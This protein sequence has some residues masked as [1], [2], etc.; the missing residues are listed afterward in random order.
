VRIGAYQR[1]LSELGERVERYQ[2][3][4]GLDGGLMLARRI[5]CCRQPL[6]DIADHGERPVALGR[7]PLLKWLGI[8]VEIGEKFATVQLGRRL[9]VRALLRPGQPFEGVEVG[10][11]VLNSAV[12]KVGDQVKRCARSQRLAQFQET[13]AKTVARLFRTLV[14]PQQVGKSL[15]AD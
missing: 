10:D 8:D 2:P 15:A 14:R 4:P 11:H 6:Q 9:Q 3:A 1:A 5:L 7:E 13:I 12:G